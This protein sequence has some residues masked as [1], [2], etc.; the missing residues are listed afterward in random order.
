MPDPSSAA[1]MRAAESIGRYYM[2]GPLSDDGAV[3]SIIDAEMGLRELVEAAQQAI[4]QFE[5]QVSVMEQNGEYYPN[6]ASEAKTRAEELRHA[7]HLAAKE[8][9]VGRE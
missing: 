6:A 2:L 4:E 8:K 7:L 1:A 9:E 3:A 5:Y